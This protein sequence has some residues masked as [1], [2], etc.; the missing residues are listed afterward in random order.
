MFTNGGN[1]VAQF[2]VLDEQQVDN[3]VFSKLNFIYSILTEGVVNCA[4]AYD[5]GDGLSSYL[6][7]WDTV[8]I[9]GSRCLIIY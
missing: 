2:Q 7:C 8:E 1:E 3:G 6:T 4:A 5:T 9:V